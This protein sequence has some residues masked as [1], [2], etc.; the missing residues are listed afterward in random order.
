MQL[1]LVRAVGPGQIPDANDPILIMGRRETVA[2]ANRRRHSGVM[3]LFLNKQWF[4]SD[5]VPE[6]DGVA[7]S[8]GE[9]PAVG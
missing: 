1:E 4:S 6:M 3:L 5:D 8:A 7:P 2:R 9:C